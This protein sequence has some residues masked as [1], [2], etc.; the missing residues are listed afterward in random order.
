MPFVLHRTP[1]IGSPHGPPDRSRWGLFC[2]IENQT[3]F[4]DQE[5][6]FP[7]MVY[8]RV[9]ILFCETVR[10]FKKS[11]QKNAH[12]QKLYLARISTPKTHAHVSI[13]SRERAMRRNCKTEEDA[14]ARRG[15]EAAKE[16]TRAGGARR[17]GHPKGSSFPPENNQTCFG[18][19]VLGFAKW[20]SNRVNP[21]CCA[22]LEHAGRSPQETE[23][24]WRV[25][26]KKSG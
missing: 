23:A 25:P 11:F 19:R 20:L 26:T 10:A 8:R 18:Q 17:T 3:Y 21:N 5:T 4:H 9:Y 13:H 15:D 7:D 12:K 1:A 6:P 2:R 16:G 14:G 24:C 22:G